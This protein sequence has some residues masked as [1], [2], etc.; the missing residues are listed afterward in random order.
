MYTSATV[1]RSAFAD[2]VA[3]TRRSTCM[4]IETCTFGCRSSAV[5][6][7]RRFLQLATAY[8]LAT[9]VGPDGPRHFLKVT[10]KHLDMLPNLPV[11]MRHDAELGFRVRLAGSLYT[12][13]EL[14]EARREGLEAPA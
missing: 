2:P 3:T 5:S 13:T 1:R 12:L 8:G 9:H 11:G 6:S 4:R 14:P 7:T 10:P